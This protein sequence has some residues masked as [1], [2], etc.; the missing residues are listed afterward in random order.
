MSHAVPIMTPPAKVAFK[1]CSILS[2]PLLILGEKTQV[3]H[4]EEVK[5]S[6]VFKTTL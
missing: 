6:A 3:V 4:T 5:D 1:M 2:F